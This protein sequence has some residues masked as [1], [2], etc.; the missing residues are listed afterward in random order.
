MNNLKDL[1]KVPLLYIVFFLSFTSCVK[2]VDLNQIDEVQLSPTAIVDLIDLTLEADLLAFEQQEPISFDRE[3]TFE[4]VTEDLEKNVTSV[5]LIFE[6]ANSL[7][8]N[9]TATLYFLTE[10][11]GVSNIVSFDILPG[12]QDQPETSSITTT[13]VGAE[14]KA[15]MESSKIRINMEMQP[16]PGATEGQLQLNSSAAYNFE[17]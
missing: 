12:S 14:L 9:F 10:R 8:R 1:L 13:F 4:V 3:V 6:Y 2:D 5:D 16:G 17:F 15:L 11:N 7:P